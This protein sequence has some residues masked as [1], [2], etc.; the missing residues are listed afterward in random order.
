MGKAALEV[1]GP[2]TQSRPPSLP[3]ISTKEFVVAEGRLLP[4]R[5]GNRSGE[6]VPSQRAHFPA[7]LDFL[8][9]KKKMP[10]KRALPFPRWCFD[11]DPSAVG[12][13]RRRKGKKR[14]GHMP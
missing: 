1:E 14:S 4:N 9:K 10:Q 2:L 7:K 3:F 13:G 5:M 6:R 12:K 11:I 8:E